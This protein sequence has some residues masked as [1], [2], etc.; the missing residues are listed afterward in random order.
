[1]LTAINVNK[2]IRLIWIRC[3]V[4]GKTNCNPKYRTRD[5]RKRRVRKPSGLFLTGFRR[6]ERKQPQQIKSRRA[7]VQFIPRLLYS[8]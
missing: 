6:I 7:F 8:G 4:S 1:M 2:T 5:P 3:G